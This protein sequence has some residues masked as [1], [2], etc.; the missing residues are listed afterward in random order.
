MILPWDLIQEDLTD[1]TGPFR[2]PEGPGLGITLYLDAVTQAE[3]FYD[4]EVIMSR[5]TNDPTEANQTRIK[6]NQLD[7]I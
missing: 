4:T 3:A 5:R 2:V 7:R 6:C 1:P